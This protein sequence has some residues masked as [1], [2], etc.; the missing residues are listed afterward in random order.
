MGDGVAVAE[1]AAAIEHLARRVGQV[2]SNE[3]KHRA[4][5]LS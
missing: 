4:L 5:I 2:F 1:E 3:S